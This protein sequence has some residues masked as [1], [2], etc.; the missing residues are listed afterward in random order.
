MPRIS[1]GAFLASVL[2]IGML[3]RVQA[4]PMKLYI[5]G[6][7]QQGYP[8]SFQ[9]PDQEFDVSDGFPGFVQGSGG[10]TQFGWTPAGWTKAI[11]GYITI[12]VA[13]YDET[14]QGLAYGYLSGRIE[15]AFIHYSSI[16][17]NLGGGAT[18]EAKLDLDNL[19]YYT[20]DSGTGLPIPSTIDRVPS[21]FY[22]LKA[23]LVGRMTG[24]G[25]NIYETTLTIPAVAAVPEPGTVVIFLA[26]AGGGL[27]MLK[28][29]A[30]S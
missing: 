25:Q 12:G 30:A 11:D 28:R 29:R 22:D 13:L 9:V 7:V 26:A 21:W 24:G 2:M 6:D 3:G 16:N 14:G 23:T 1:R 8:G 4:A 27:V 5:W 10:P 15:G 18:G 20:H 19:Y 17:S